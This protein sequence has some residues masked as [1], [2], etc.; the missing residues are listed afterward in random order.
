MN[1]GEC[2]KMVEN[3]CTDTENFDRKLISL[4]LYQAE[5]TRAEEQL[6]QKDGY[7]YNRKMF[8]TTEKIP[9]K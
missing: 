7:Q 2:S 6:Q 4:S 9:L 8:T 5:R 3:L 1:D